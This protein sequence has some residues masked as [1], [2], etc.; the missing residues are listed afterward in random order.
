[1]CLVETPPLIQ[2]LVVP[3]AWQITFLVLVK[4][5]LVLRGRPTHET[6]ST[7]IP[8]NFCLNFSDEPRAGHSE[9]N[10]DVK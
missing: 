4:I 10:T 2:K 7:F 5:T 6:P 8:I 3:E 9:Y 1:M